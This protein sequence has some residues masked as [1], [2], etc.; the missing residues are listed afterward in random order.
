MIADIKF[1][2]LAVPESVDSKLHQQT[3]YVCY[4]G[5]ANVYKIKE[6]RMVKVIKIDDIE[7]ARKE[8]IQEK[9]EKVDDMEYKI[10]RTYS[11][12]VFSGYVESRKGQEVVIRNARR[13]W[14]WSGA[15]SLSQLANEGVKN[16]ED[17][18]FAQEVDKIEV[19]QVI[20]ILDCTEKA[21]K[22]IAEVQVWQQ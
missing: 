9:A 1:G 3:S 18:K 5:E 12:G 15:S 7:Y 22:N 10:I 4:I 20:E 13:L 11:A 21:R 14:Y 2:G 17:C 16:A 6:D 8:G 19:L